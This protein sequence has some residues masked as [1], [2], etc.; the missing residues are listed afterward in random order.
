[1][2]FLFEDML[3][4]FG[5]V[6]NII[7]SESWSCIILHIPSFNLNFQSS[8]FVLL[9]CVRTDVVWLLMGQ[10]RVNVILATRMMKMDAVLKHRVSLLSY[11]YLQ[12]FVI[13]A[14][15]VIDKDVVHWKRGV[16]RRHPS[17]GH[18][19]ILIYH[20]WEILYHCRW[21]RMPHGFLHEW[22]VSNC[23]RKSGVCVR[24]W[25]RE[26]LCGSMSHHR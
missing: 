5:K 8:K 18:K 16:L 23:G 2:F 3:V 13:F 11:L 15:Y 17:Q 20:S 7:C 10:L 24:Y 25:I 19:A 4:S 21:Q 1:M 9:N 12:K 6:N 14:M 22:K 26:R